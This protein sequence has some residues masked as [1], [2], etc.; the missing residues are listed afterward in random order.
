MSDQDAL[1]EKWWP[2]TERGERVK[3]ARP[4]EPCDNEAAQ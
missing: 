2:E 1:P 3:L 4:P